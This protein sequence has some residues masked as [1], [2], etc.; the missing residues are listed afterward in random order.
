MMCL[1]SKLHLY[2]W[3]YEGEN[4]RERILE[5]EWRPKNKEG[6]NRLERKGELGKEKQREAKKKKIKKNKPTKKP[7]KEQ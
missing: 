2:L 6:E 1:Y 3:K 7:K 4:V 5:R